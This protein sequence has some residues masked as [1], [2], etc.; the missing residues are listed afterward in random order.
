MVDW[1]DSILLGLAK[2]DDDHK[3]VLRHINHFIDTVET[4]SGTVAIHDSFRR[5]ER[6]IYRHLELEEAMLDA[7]GFTGAEAHKAAHGALTDDLEAIWEDMLADP[8]FRP[9]E[10]ARAWLESWLFKH[11]STEDFRYRDWI[12]AAGL[13]DRVD[14][15][16]PD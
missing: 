12:V 2:V 1:D 9:D 4:R 14:A 5:M 6:R 11:V 13:A 16:F 8:H 7:L 15:H 10:A 3:S